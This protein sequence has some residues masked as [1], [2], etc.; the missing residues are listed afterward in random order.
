MCRKEGMGIAPW[1]V[2][3]QGKW[4]SKAQIEERKQSG[5]KFR[6]SQAELD[7]A[8]VKMAGELEKIAKAIGGGAT[9]TSVAIAWCLLKEPYVFPIGELLTP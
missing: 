8:D 5:E 2:I 4:Q 1:G 9:I 3:N 7:P 6:R